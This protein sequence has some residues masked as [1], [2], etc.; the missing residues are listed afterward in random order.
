MS[1]LASSDLPCEPC[2]PAYTELAPPLMT[3]ALFDIL[4]QLFIGP[5]LA[6]PS[7]AVGT[8]V[9]VHVTSSPDIRTGCDRASCAESP[10]AWPRRDTVIGYLFA[11]S[12]IRS[13]V[14]STALSIQHGAF[15]DWLNVV[16]TSSPMGRFLR[17]QKNCSHR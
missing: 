10:N 6:V 7:T 11:T 13:T 17:R 3:E 16:H 15:R 5:C 14:P 1:E 8:T 9:D 12:Y 4:R 2:Q